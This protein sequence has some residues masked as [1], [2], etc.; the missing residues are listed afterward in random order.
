MRKL[1]QRNIDFLVSAHQKIF[2]FVKESPK[3]NN[4]KNVWV[5]MYVSLAMMLPF[6]EYVLCAKSLGYL[7]FFLLWR[8]WWWACPAWS[9]DGSAT[10]DWTWTQA[11]A[12]S[13]WIPGP[14]ASHCLL[15]IWCCPLKQ[16][17]L[18]TDPTL[19]KKYWK[20]LLKSNHVSP[21]GKWEMLP[22]FETQEKFYQL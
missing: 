17:L 13:V 19:I 11:S 1:T 6:M 20:T 2:C 14:R 21:R 18:E 12:C 22:R 4:K 16:L 8:G 3:S 9:R 10:E 5:N 15:S 7:Q